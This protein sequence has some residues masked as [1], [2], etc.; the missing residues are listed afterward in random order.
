MSQNL[1]SMLTSKNLKLN[2]SYVSILAIAAIIYSLLSLWA[3]PQGDDIIFM[4]VYRNYNNFSNDFNLQSWIEMAKETRNNDNSRLCNF[5]SI[6]TTIISPTN[7]IFPWINGL[8]TAGLIAFTTAFWRQR[9]HRATV[10]CIAWGILLVALPWRNCIFIRDYSLN[11]IVASFITL[12]FIATFVRYEE[13]GWT[14]SATILIALFA[15]PTGLWSEGFTVT[16]CFGIGIYGLSNLLC[17]NKKSPSPQ[18]YLIFAIYILAGLWITFSPGVLARTNREAPMALNFDLKYLVFMAPSFG[19]ILLLIL[20]IGSTRLRQAFKN[21]YFIIFTCSAIPGIM[22]TALVNHTPRTS[23]WPTLCSIIY[24]GILY[25]KGIARFINKGISKYLAVTILLTCIAS[26]VYSDIYQHRLYEEY[27]AIMHKIESSKSGSIYHDIIFPERCSLFSLYMPTRTCWVTPFHYYCLQ[28]Y[29]HKAPISVVPT[30]LL[31]INQ[32][33]EV[34]NSDSTIFRTGSALWTSF[35]I[36]PKKQ[37]QVEASLKMKNGQELQAAMGT[38]LQF[39]TKEGAPLT[40]IKLYN[41]DARDIAEI[42]S[43]NLITD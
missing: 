30:D 20:N 40:Y 17:K 15:I 21:P 8:M 7:A 5:V 6:F 31:N 36:N 28:D 3:L 23:F 25:R 18:F 19:A 33:K 10:A 37:C 16:T 32:E 11:Y 27:L 24:L 26:G 2:F 43:F 4:S 34:I 42:T 12:S 35:Q 13:K 39:I 41:I 1:S 9:N 29:Y 14:K 22:L 38:L